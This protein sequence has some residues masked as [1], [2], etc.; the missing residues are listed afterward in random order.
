M[1]MENNKRKEFSQNI[2]MFW[3]TIA[4]YTVVLVVY[5]VLAGS[6]EKGTLTLKVLDPIVILLFI[7]IIVSLLTFAS[8]HYRK[9]IIQIEHDYIIL[10]SRFGIRKLKRSEIEDIKF[11]KERI[12][13]TRR[14]YSVVK[15]KFINR[16]RWLR[17]RPSAF[18]N[19][20]EL[21][22]TLQKLR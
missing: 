15:I 2:D 14:K 3:R 13:R 18:D 22:E 8:K 6:W 5:S 7:I 11:T 12:F 17:I 19:P 20:N 1:N 4:V 21:I 9:K 10:K 16:K